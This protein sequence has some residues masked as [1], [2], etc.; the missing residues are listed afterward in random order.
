[1]NFFL[2]K[3]LYP[4]TSAPM[5][6]RILFLLLSLPLSAYTQM[7]DVD[8]LTRELDL[9]ILDAAENPGTPPAERPANHLFLNFDTLPKLHPE[10]GQLTPL[11]DD[12]LYRIDLP[13]ATYLVAPNPAR[14][15]KAYALLS[16]AILQLNLSVIFP[17]KIAL[18]ADGN[19]S[20]AL[21]LEKLPTEHLPSGMDL[22][23]LPHSVFAAVE[24]DIQLLEKTQPPVLDAYIRLQ[25]LAESQG[26]KLDRKEFFFFPQ[27][28]GKVLFGLRVLNSSHTG[29]D[30]KPE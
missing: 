30:P 7:P 18:H 25:S 13:A 21:A 6:L 24:A 23:P 26:L 11:I 10:K 12:T 22:S 14:L 15:D 5:R 17:V 20:V 19:F 4:D 16:D 9:S 1:M 29:D 28:P 2:S 3:V 27:S 8:D